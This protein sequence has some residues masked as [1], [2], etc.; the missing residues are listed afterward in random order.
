M[1]LVAFNRD[2]I[3]G[4]DFIKVN[5]C[6]LQFW[7]GLLDVLAPKGP[8][9]PYIAAPLVDT[10][11]PLEREIVPNPTRRIGRMGPTVTLV[12]LLILLDSFVVI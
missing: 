9:H 8:R 6:D 12:L 4:K 7:F 2:L 3:C 1:I 11:G 10:G 5:Y